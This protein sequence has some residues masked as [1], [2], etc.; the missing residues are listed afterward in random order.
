M[1]KAVGTI[2]GVIKD[3]AWEPVIFFSFARKD[4]EMYAG[5]LLKTDKFD[6][7]TEEEKSAIDEASSTDQINDQ[8][9]VP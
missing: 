9:V 8:D 1:L 4:C 2:L 5:S 6:F 3:K 7:N